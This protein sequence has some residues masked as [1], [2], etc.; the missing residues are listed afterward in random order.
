M[1]EPNSPEP[2]VIEFEPFS[3]EK[4]SEYNDLVHN[5]VK[6]SGYMDEEIRNILIEELIYYFEREYSVEETADIIQNRVSICLSEKYQQLKRLLKC[7]ETVLLRSL[8]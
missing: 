5:A 6:N 4:A 2:T 8:T 7:S 3:D 1:Y